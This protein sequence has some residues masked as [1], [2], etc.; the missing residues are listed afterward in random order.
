MFNLDATIDQVQNSKKTMAKAIITNPEVSNL[1][2]YYIDSQTA[3]VKSSTKF[4]TDLGQHV[5]NE[6]IK[7][8]QDAA[9]FDYI[10]YA[11]R[12]VRAVQQPFA[13]QNK[14]SKAK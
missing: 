11:D 10:G 14:E 6:T 8:A 5:G 7:A 13:A 1:V 2:E 12:F 3:F 9:K 4:F